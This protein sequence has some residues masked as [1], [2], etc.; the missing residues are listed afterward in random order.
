M[1]VLCYIIVCTVEI[2]SLTEVYHIWGDQDTHSVI[3]YRKPQVL[4]RRHTMVQLEVGSIP[5]K[6]QMT[7]GKLGD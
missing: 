4:P 6:D 2:T 7:Y 3:H 5:I 1:Y